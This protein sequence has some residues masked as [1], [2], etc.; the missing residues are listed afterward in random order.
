MGDTYAV[1]KDS[2]EGRVES[3]LGRQAGQLQEHE[4]GVHKTN[5]QDIP[6]RNSSLV[7]QPPSLPSYLR[8]SRPIASQSLEQTRLEVSGLYRA[9]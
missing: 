8:S 2:D 9:L 4:Q 7:V 6:V 5:R 1:E 3:I